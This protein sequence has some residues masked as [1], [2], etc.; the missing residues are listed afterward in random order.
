MRDF[1]RATFESANNRLTPPKGRSGQSLLRNAEGSA[2]QVH[3]R[4]IFVQS[5]DSGR[6][7][8]AAIQGSY[9]WMTNLTA[10]GT[11]IFQIPDGDETSQYV[12]YMPT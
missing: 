10:C 1:G 3:P 11:R 4:H 2:S 8:L 12:L 9:K 5:V 7:H 6:D